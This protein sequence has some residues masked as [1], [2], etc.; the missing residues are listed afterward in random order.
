MTL[1]EQHGK[2]FSPLLPQDKL[3]AIKNL[4]IGV[5]DKLFVTFNGT[6]A[7]SGRSELVW[8]QPDTALPKGKYSSL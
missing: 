5:V 1:Q 8:Q 3:S 2:L 7:A 4:G 6:T